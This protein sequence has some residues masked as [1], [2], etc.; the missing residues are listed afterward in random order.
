ME[1]PVKV[2]LIARRSKKGFV[3]PY[4]SRMDWWQKWY[5]LCSDHFIILKSFF[6]V[7]GNWVLTLYIL[8]K[9]FFSCSN[10]F[11]FGK[12]P[13]V[14]TLY[15]VFRHDIWCFS[16]IFLVP[17]FFLLKL[18]SHK[19]PT[20]YK[21]KY[22]RYIPWVIIAVIILWQYA[23]FLVFSATFLWFLT[24]LAEVPGF[25]ILALHA[26]VGFIIQALYFSNITQII[27]QYHWYFILVR[28]IV[29]FIINC[30]WVFFVKLFGSSSIL[31]GCSI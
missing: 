1:P 8:L 4:L 9:L 24:Y 18:G 25:L 11:L 20:S 13:I 3:Y 5:I 30:F 15:I 29:F 12:G 23:L 21:K 22:F 19:P 28:M 31:K 6:F 2:F 16:I 14:W 17:A 10:Y 26:S 7:R 27:C